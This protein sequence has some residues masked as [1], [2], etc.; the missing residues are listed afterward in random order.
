[1]HSLTGLRRRVARSWTRDLAA[2]EAARAAFY[3]S[4]ASVP[5]A[6]VLFALAGLLG[7]EQALEGFVTSVV[8][9]LPEQAGAVLSALVGEIKS[10]STPGLLSVSAVL[11]LLWASSVVESLALGINRAYRV[12][13]RRPWWRKKAIALALLLVNSLLLVAGAVGLLAGPRL[14]AALGLGF[15][16]GLMGWPLIWWIMTLEL[17]ILYY[18]LPTPA[19][20]R[21]GWRILLGAMSGTALWV[22]GTMLFRLYLARYSILNLVYGVLGGVLVWMLW[23]YL[24]AA[25]V[26]LGAEVAAVLE[27]RAA[28]PRDEPASES[29]TDR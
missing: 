24:S 22:I 26:F 5:A 13:T 29:G 14:A 8:A 15:V 2:A 16:S 3:L 28:R 9:G 20:P 4:L 17:W 19:H 12:G 25:A 11:T 18:V 21:S 10:A 1:M 27:R 7:T 6:M 23:L